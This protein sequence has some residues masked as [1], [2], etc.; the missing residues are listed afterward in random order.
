M[1][2]LIGR[3]FVDEVGLVERVYGEIWG[4][5]AMEIALFLYI[6]QAIN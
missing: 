5:R 3:W 4:K 6:K 1:R 2:A